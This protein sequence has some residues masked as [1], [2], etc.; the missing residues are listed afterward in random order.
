MN[1]EESKKRKKM[2]HLLYLEQKIKDDTASTYKSHPWE[3]LLDVFILIFRGKL[4]IRSSFI[5]LFY[6]SSF[7]LRWLRVV[8]DTHW[9][10]NLI[11]LPVWG[12]TE[13]PVH[14]LTTITDHRESLMTQTRTTHTY[15]YTHAAQ[16]NTHMHTE[17][18]TSLRHQMP[19]WVTV[20][21]S[22]DKPR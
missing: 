7:I 16:N 3:G 17:K 13:D 20:F 1:Q 14:S 19:R 18:V 4:L 10:R 15:I 6:F 8:I 5:L 11:P 22:L 2:W 9:S 21:L 12:E